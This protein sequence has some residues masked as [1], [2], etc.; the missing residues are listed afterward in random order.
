MKKNKMMRAA[1]ALLVAVL[2]T[3]SVISGTFAKYVTNVSANAT[4]RVAKWGFENTAISF[5]DLFS[6]T[7]VTD[8][9]VITGNSVASSNTD[10]LIAPGTKGAA[11]FSFVYNDENAKPEVAYSFVVDASESTC[12]T[13]IQENTS[14]RWCLDD[15]NYDLTW[16][17]LLDEINALDGDKTY[18]P[19]ELPT[20][21]GHDDSHTIR[22]QWKFYEND[23]ADAKD[24]EMGNLA[25]STDLKVYLKIS[26]T[27]TQLD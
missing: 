22:W 2:L 13:E 10:E 5:D 27:A 25:T 7:Y 18:G 20:G 14:I 4:A 1:S 21:F 17:Q 16:E 26:V 15:E 6:T 3:T 8:G 11:T 24:T 19:N 9:T 23:S 12:A